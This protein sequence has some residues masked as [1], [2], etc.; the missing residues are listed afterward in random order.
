M[1]KI[2]CL[3]TLHGI[4]FEQPP[5]IRNKE[6]KMERDKEGNW[7][8]FGTNTGYADLFHHY[9]HTHPRLN[10]LLSDDPKRSRT[11]AGENGAIYVQS[12][13][14][15][16]QESSS[17]EEG[18]KRLGTWSEDR[19]KIN[20]DGAP[21]VANGKLLSHVALVYSNLEATSAPF[22]VAIMTLVMSIF[23]ASRYG[24]F[25]GLIYM[26]ATDVKALFKK[27]DKPRPELGVSSLPRTDMKARHKKR[28]QHPSISSS[29]GFWKTLHYLID[30]VGSYICHNEERER[31]RGFVLEALKRLAVR[32]DVGEI[33]LNTHSQGSII[34][35]DVL[36]Y[37]PNEVTDKIKCFVTAGSPLRKYVSLFSWG[38]QV[39]CLYTLEPW[40]NFWDQ[41]DPVADR[42]EPPCSWR[43]GDEV[44]V[45]SME[46]LFSR[47][48][49]NSE[50]LRHIRVKDHPIDNVKYSC[51]GGLR[52]HNYWDNE[53]QFIPELVKIVCD[54]I[55][56]ECSAPA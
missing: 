7:K 39:Q 4:G 43:V 19:K 21:L 54:P 6:G 48:E 12:R 16:D 10:P 35:F 37:L 23:S 56:D 2:T 49:P 17:T 5:N 26:L 3:I 30:D 8:E 13:W 44:P 24:S 47:I 53:I 41:C 50:E 45:A 34:A 52:A 36:H 46:R 32:E 51:G 25:K 29:P 33:I 11:H 9:L 1:E 28:K 42:L 18:L 20:T 31:V 38:N 15:E 27:P 14:S 40:I 22:G 55:E